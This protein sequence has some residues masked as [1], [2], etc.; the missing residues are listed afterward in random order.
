MA[1]DEIELEAHGEVV[2]V[3][4]DLVSRLAAAAADQAGVSLRHRDLSLALGIALD[5]G[6]LALGRG[7]L[8]ALRA[9]LEEEPDGFGLAGADLLR[10][11]AAG[12]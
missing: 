11:L 5:S 3:P 4:R 6:R 8:W 7:E 12:A 9:V 10:V 1:A 2:R